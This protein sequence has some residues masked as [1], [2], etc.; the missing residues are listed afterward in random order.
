MEHVYGFGAHA[1]DG[2]VIALAYHLK[3]GRQKGAILARFVAAIGGSSRTDAECTDR[4]LLGSSA[5][6]V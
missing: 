2:F 5:R 1:F 4:E 6:M 3:G